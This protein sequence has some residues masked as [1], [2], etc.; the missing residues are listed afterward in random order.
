MGRRREEVTNRRRPPKHNRHVWIDFGDDLDPMQG[1]VL[2]WRRH[3]Y[4]WAA[5][6][7]FV[8]ENHDPIAVVQQWIPA[9]RLTPVPMARHDLPRKSGRPALH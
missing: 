9:E 5:L 8:D 1:L 2:E 7:V 4:R 3:S 6:V